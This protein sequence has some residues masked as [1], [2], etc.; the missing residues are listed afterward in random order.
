VTAPAPG[1]KT[2]RPCSGGRRLAERLFVILAVP[3]AVLFCVV[4]GPARS[5]VAVSATLTSNYLYRG[6]SLSDG[7]PTLDLALAVDG[8][9][10]LYGGV[11]LIG[12]T[13]RNGRPRWLGDVEYL[14]YAT[15]LGG[16]PTLDLGVHNLDYRTFGYCSGDYDEAEVY[17]GLIAG[18]FNAYVHYSPNAF[19]P[20]AR[21]IYAEANGAIGLPRPF[22]LVAHA[23]VVTPLGGGL[24][25]YDVSAGVA[26]AFRRAEARLTWTTTRPNTDYATRFATGRGVVA[27]ALTWL[28]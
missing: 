19:N 25:R 6:M 27:L 8:R 20:G 24:D 12:E 23:G 11:S 10:G 13:A 28:F 17:A 3:C 21:T 14:G 15:R 9:G 1:P 26:A 18:H 4:A 5:Q 22:R 7:Q 2:P 16:G